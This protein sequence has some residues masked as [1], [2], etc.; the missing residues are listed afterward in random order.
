MCENE[1]FL[2]VTRC[3]FLF[4][5][6]PPSSQVFSDGGGSIELIS[7]TFQ[8]SPTINIIRQVIV[9]PLRSTS[10]AP[11]ASSNAARVSHPL[12][13]G[14]FAA[15][16]AAG[17]DD[18]EDEDADEDEEED[19]N[20]DNEMESRVAVDARNVN[21]DAGG[22]INATTMAN[23][24]L[25]RRIK[26][27]LREDH[28]I[29][30]KIYELERDIVTKRQHMLPGLPQQQPLPQQ[31]AQCC[32]LCN[33]VGPPM[34]S[35]LAFVIEKIVIAALAIFALLLIAE[36]ARTHSIL[37]AVNTNFLPL[38]S[39]ATFNGDESIQSPQSPS[40]SPAEY[41]IIDGVRYQKIHRRSVHVDKGTNNEGSG[42]RARKSLREQRLEVEAEAE[43]G[44]KLWESLAQGQ[45][46]GDEGELK[47]EPPAAAAAP[48]YGSSRKLLNAEEEGI[49][50]RMQAI[51]M[52]REREQ[53]RRR[54][55]VEAEEREWR[56]AAQ[57]QE[58][59][60]NKREEAERFASENRRE[61]LRHD[62][63]M[64]DP[65]ISDDERKLVRLRELEEVKET[66]KRKK[67]EEKERT[68]APARKPPS[69]RGGWL[70]DA[71]LD[72]LSKD[73]SC[74]F[75]VMDVRSDPSYRD[76]I[77]AIG[78]DHPYILR[79]LVDK[80]KARKAWTRE[81][82][83][84]AFGNRTITMDAQ[85]AIVWN[86]G[87]SSV[88]LPLKDF[89]R[90]IRSREGEV[91]D[92]SAERTSS[93]MGRKGSAD[94]DV[95]DQTKK[96]IDLLQQYL[97]ND[98]FSFDLRIVQSI[99]E[100]IDDFDIPE[101][102][103]DWHWISDF[104]HGGYS[105][106]KAAAKARL[107]KEH[108]DDSSTILSL[109]PT[110]SGLPFHSHGRAWIGL[111]YGRKWWFVYHPAVAGP[112][113]I[114]RQYNPMTS[115]HSWFTRIRP[116]LKDYPKSPL[117]FDVRRQYD[118]R[119]YRPFE[120]IQEEGDILYIP[121]LWNH[122]TYNIGEVIGVGGQT[123]IGLKLRF[124]LAQEYTRINPNNPEMLKQ[125]YLGHLGYAYTDTYT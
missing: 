32:R 115:T 31:L 119:G 86:A 108:M 71:E 102:M 35:S 65:R 80:W 118:V 88:P 53:A 97:S 120:C 28:L 74:D 83:W 14:S 78:E 3:L 56:R 106:A 58:A 77:K 93:S 107:G 121:A 9:M 55:S 40:S 79:G 11:R 27:L 124:D 68:E 12:A 60:K 100:L 34:S 51:A 112:D 29:K 61:K 104:Q 41:V 54:A 103:G 42:T 116:K 10:G 19:D 1:T 15:A 30:K 114:V 94:K 38:L 105:R 57:E 69:Y 16:G 46:Q 7:A 13:G 39:P 75:P 70:E 47:K 45:G 92:A 59:V 26:E 96:N 5:L 125:L 113:D 72:E 37:Y 87:K 89:L 52:A 6:Q 122:Q 62:R 85:T 73:V 110:K 90:G 64:E 44:K 67:Q 123:N 21:G 4:P 98:S 23:H 18:R 91:S 2:K 63:L 82:L 50:T 36:Y 25:E 95:H 33:R 76:K 8:R 24:E 22:T 43:R 20:N 49:D 109:G 117:K 17:A 111:V 66:E 101:E 99:P 48:M 84:K 81:N